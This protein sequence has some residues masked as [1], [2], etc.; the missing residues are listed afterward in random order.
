[1][2]RLPSELSELPSG[3]GGHGPG[4]CVFTKTGTEKRVVPGVWRM[5]KPFAAGILRWI[6][7]G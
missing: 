5:E 7:R 3:V 1:V 2:V 6:N 4:S